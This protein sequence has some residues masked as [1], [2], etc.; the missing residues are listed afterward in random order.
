M[1]LRSRNGD[2]GSV[3]P[4][5]RRKPGGGSGNVNFGRYRSISVAATDRE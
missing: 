5:P 2:L 3:R 1:L 4:T